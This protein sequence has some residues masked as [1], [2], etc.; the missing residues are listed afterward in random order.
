MLHPVDEAAVSTLRFA[1]KSIWSN[2]IARPLTAGLDGHPSE[3]RAARKTARVNASQ[4]WI[5]KLRIRPQGSPAVDLSRHH[6]VMILIVSAVVT[7]AV[8]GGVAVVKS[9]K[10]TLAGPVHGTLTG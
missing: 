8:D 4:R 9:R 1:R 7:E 3:I 5:E 10:P 2:D 6:A